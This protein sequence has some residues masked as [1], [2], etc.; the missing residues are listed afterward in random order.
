MKVERIVATK[1]HIELIVPQMPV[2]SHVYAEARLPVVTGDAKRPH[3]GK[4]MMVTDKK[5]K[6]SIIFDRY[7]GDFD[8]MATPNTNESCIQLFR[9]RNWCYY[10]LY[11]QRWFWRN[12]FFHT[13][14]LRRNGWL[15]R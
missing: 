3:H 4:I 1:E 13:N 5:Q 12:T 9:C 7:V 8:H 10:T 14:A 6:H 15:S 11:A 2:V